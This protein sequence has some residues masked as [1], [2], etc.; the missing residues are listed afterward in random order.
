MTKFGHWFRAAG[1]HVW[2]DLCGGNNDLTAVVHPDVG[3]MEGGMKR[4]TQITQYKGLFGFG[5]KSTYFFVP[6]IIEKL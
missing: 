1:S 3:E 6:V 5:F 2:P 4:F